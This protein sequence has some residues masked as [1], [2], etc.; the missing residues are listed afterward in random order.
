IMI[1]N[2]LRGAL[3][4]AMAG[5]RL[6]SEERSVRLDSARALQREMAPER[7]PLVEKALEQESDTQIRSILLLAAATAR[8]ESED[9]AVRL[10]AVK[11]LSASSNASLV[12]L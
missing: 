12:P 11:A 8:L 4:G 10:E 1:N 7:L 2:R 3:Q 6:L 5:L 9:A